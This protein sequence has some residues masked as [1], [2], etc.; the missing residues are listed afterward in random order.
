MASQATSQAIRQAK[1]TV[2]RFTG[3]QQILRPL[4]RP[5]VPEHLLTL[6][7]LSP[8]QISSLLVSAITSKYL[9]KTY[10]NNAHR[11]GLSGSTIALLFSKRSTRTRVASESASMLLGAHP[12]FLGSGDIQMGVNESVLDTIKVVA[13]MVDGIMA[14][15]GEHS[16]IEEMAKHSPVPVINAL[17]KLYHP[18]QILADLLTLS[19]TYSDSIP[20]PKSIPKRRSHNEAHAYFMEH[21]SPLVSLEGKKIAW[22][23]DTN[24]IT[25]EL[26]VTCP[27]LGMKMSVAAPKGY[28]KVEEVVWNRVLEGGHADSVTLTN[29]PEEALHDADIV[30]TDTWISMGMEDE[31]AARLE[32][33][34]GYQITNSMV[35]SAGAKPDWKFLHCLPRKPQEVD[36]EVFY[37]PRSL[38]FPEAENRKWTTV[39]CFKW[40]MVRIQDSSGPR[41]P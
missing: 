14:R 40:P 27:R 17:S 15:V 28:D 23:G 6:A 19:E 24:N 33:F 37:G 7:D 35:E 25:N 10:G 21:A 20:L 32:A 29:S 31:K 12:M 9:C 39:A 3:Q 5:S 1:S 18:T 38:V 4:R 22:V 34:K 26:L 30:V 8:A 2:S 13:S 11:T 36:D 41:Q 16:E